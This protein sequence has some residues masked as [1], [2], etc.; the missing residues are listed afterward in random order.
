M[1][2]TEPSVEPTEPESTRPPQKKPSIKIANAPVGGSGG[3]GPRACV[4]VSWLGD[5]IPDGAT[6]K[7]E[8]I[9]FTWS[10]TD[11]KNI[12]KLD[13]SSCRGVA[14]APLCA[15]QEWKGGDSLTCS[16]GVKQV[17]AADPSQTVAVKLRVTV[18][19]ESQ[20]DCDSLARGGQEKGRKSS[21]CRAG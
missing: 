3:L 18:T 14:E 15:G 9:Y 1:L 16:V 2:S 21:Q 13:Q 19:C 11:G 6:I 20:A 7:L 4:D 8:S 17:A 12:F 10:G 5:P